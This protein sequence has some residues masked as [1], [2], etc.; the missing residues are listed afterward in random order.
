MYN[1]ERHTFMT[2]MKLALPLAIV[3]VLALWVMT[4]FAG[5]V[6]PPP[7][8]I[9]PEHCMQLVYTNGQPIA[10]LRWQA[11]KPKQEVIDIP[12]MDGTPAV[13]RALIDGWIEDAYA[14]EGT[15]SE[16]LVRIANQCNGKDV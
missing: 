14:F 9:D 5:S 2:I 1:P 16:W 13:V 12:Y 10:A 3:L 4:T 11:H 7:E 8:H 15:P 6:E